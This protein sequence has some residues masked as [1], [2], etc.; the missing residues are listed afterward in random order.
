MP[1]SL[2]PRTPVG[3]QHRVLLPVT[4]W[5][6][7][8]NPAP[9]GRPSQSCTGGSVT[10]DSTRQSLSGA[11]ASGGDSGRKE[12]SGSLAEAV[13]RRQNLTG[14]LKCKQDVTR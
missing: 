3:A 13:W 10:L 4:Y 5:K 14:F 1:S 2:Y 7:P 12:C 9:P 6:V 8:Y 11:P